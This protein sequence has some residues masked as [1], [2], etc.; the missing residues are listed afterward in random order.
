MPTLNWLGRDKVLTHHRDVP[1]HFLDKKFAVGN[2]QNMIIHADNLAA[3]KALLPTFAGKIKCIYIDPPYNT[4]NENWIYNDNV[5]HPAIQK[6]LGSTVGKEGEDLSRH[7]KWL[8]MMFPRLVLL[9]ELLSDDGAIFISIDDNEQA[10]LKLICDEIFGASN[11]LAQVIWERAYAPVNLKKHFS[12]SHDYIICYAKNISQ[13]VCNGLPRTSDADNRYKNPDNDPRGVWQSDNLS[14]GPV[15]ESKIYEITTPSGRKVLPPKGYCWRLDQRTFQKYVEDNRIWFGED[16]NNVPRIKRFLSEVKQSV[17]PMTIWKYTEVGHSQDATKALKE[18]FDG[19]AVMEYPKPVDLVKRCL[20]LY[21]DKDSLILDAFAGSGTTAHAVINLNA[22]DGGQRRFILIEL[23]DYAESITAERVKRVGGEFG[24]Y[25]LGAALFD[26][27]GFIN[28]AVPIERVRE[29]VWRSETGE[30]L[31]AA[32]GEEYFLGTHEGAAY[33][34]CYEA[35]RTVVLNF[36]L[37]AGLKERGRRYVIYAEACQLSEA[38]LERYKIEFRRIP[39]GI[40][41]Y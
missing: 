3:L 30:E 17:T 37:W 5:N 21:S 1:F 41:R 33:Y 13:L 32:T 18:I 39:S 38:Q 2:S 15:V 10:N 27:E 24:Y 22:A 28:A 34:F 4:G 25:E 8:C 12:P 23:E 7:D 9:R 16:G 6:W 36:K 11:F 19:R 26:E 29:Y 20:E 35:E 31:P 40:R 14:V